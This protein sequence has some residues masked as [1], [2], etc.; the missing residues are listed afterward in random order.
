MNGFRE[1]HEIFEKAGAQIV[2]ISVDSVATQKAWADS[3][4]GV[5]FPILADFHPKGAVAQAFDVYN[6]ER[7]VAKRSA[8][9]I[10]PE[11][12]IRFSYEYPR[13]VSPNPAELLKEILELRKGQ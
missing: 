12:V 10:D 1:N 13:G 2:E 11:G 3:M 4:S 8:F 6:D 9:I 5:P 7:G